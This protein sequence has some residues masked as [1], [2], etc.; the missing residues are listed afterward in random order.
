MLKREK[1]IQELAFY[2][3]LN[4]AC[5]IKELSNKFNVSEMTVRRDLSVLES[6]NVIRFIHGVAVYNQNNPANAGN[7]MN[8]TLY[9]S[10][11]LF[12][13]HIIKNKQEKINIAKEAAKLIEPE[14]SVMIDS[15]STTTYLC[16][17]IDNDFFFTA[18]CWALNIL[19][20]L[21]SKQNC[22]LVSY[23]GYFHPET[24]LFE[25]PY[26]SEFIKYTRAS[27]AFISAGGIHPDL[28]V[29]CPLSY[30]FET[31]RVAI[32]SSKTRI[33]LIDSSKFG[34][35]CS[36]HFSNVEDFDIIVTDKGVDENYQ[37]EIAAK[38]VKL[39]LA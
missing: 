1:R 33:L 30:E 37:R 15:G 25:N 6:R 34:K 26:P 19:V 10:D 13:Q 36:T 29:T 17:E 28:G 7:N 4:N 39:I 20:V 14:E 16:R 24:R 35:I 23:G 22:R 11:Y 2:L 8:G 18:I 3:K 38:G 12:R 21:S 5:T 27:K 31:K 9:G 32:E